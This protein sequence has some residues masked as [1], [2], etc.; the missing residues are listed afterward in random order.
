MQEATEEERM[1]QQQ[2]MKI[3]RD[4]KRRMKRQVEMDVN[5]SWWVSELLA[6]DYIKGWFHPEWE[7]TMQQ[8]C[9]WLR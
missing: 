6:L 3:M 7:D 5:N 1:K 8:W 9:S 2:R 4:M